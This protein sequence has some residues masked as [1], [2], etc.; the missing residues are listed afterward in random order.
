MY[1]KAYESFETIWKHKWIYPKKS[2]SYHY[3]TQ[4]DHL[5]C[6][7]KNSNRPYWTNTTGLLVESDTLIIACLLH[8]WCPWEWSEI[9][10]YQ[11]H[12]QR[13]VMV[14]LKMTCNANHAL[15]NA[16]QFYANIKN[17]LLSIRIHKRLF[18]RRFIHS[19]PKPISISFIIAKCIFHHSE[20]PYWTIVFG[21]DGLL[22]GWNEWDY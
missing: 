9:E 2:L 7:L 11:W 12:L 4:S 18:T 3:H 1:I 13:L 20:F 19:K 22:I 17:I 10:R 5:N 16:F 8:V 15:T 6:Q 14:M 21:D